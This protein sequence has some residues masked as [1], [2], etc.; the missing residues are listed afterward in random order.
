MTTFSTAAYRGIT[1]TREVVPLL[2]TLT[3]ADK[4]DD[5]LIAAM[6][7]AMDL[8]VASQYTRLQWSIDVSRLC[9]KDADLLPPV[10]FEPAKC[11]DIPDFPTNLSAEQDAIGSKIFSACSQQNMTSVQATLACLMIGT[12]AAESCGLTRRAWK[13]YAQKMWELWHVEAKTAR[14]A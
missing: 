4:A 12:M 8:A 11:P 14:G 6:S 1:P 5:I 9:G 10:R 2:R 7:E 13:E 3:P